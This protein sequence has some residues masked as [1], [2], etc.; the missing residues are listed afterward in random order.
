MTAEIIS[1]GTELLLGNI[2]NTNA[3][4]LSRELADLG[5]MVQ[6]ESTIG[7]NH[8]RL[9]DFVNEA[10]SRCDL[11]VFTGGLG[12]TADDLTKETVAACFGDELAFD[13]AEWDKITSYFARTGRET[14]PN[15]RKQA[16]VPT[17][18][19]KIINNHG[20]APGA[21]FEQDGHCAVLMPG[22]PH[23]MKA[24][25]TESVRPLLMERQNCTLH[26]VTLRVLGGESDIE[27]K[28]RDLLENPNP[29]AAIYCKTGECEIRITARARSD[30][31]GEKMCLA[32][33]TA[34]DLTKETVAA[35]FGDE[36]AFDEAEWDKITSYFAR[37]GRET[38]PN[39]RKQAMVPTK[40]HK[41]INNHG[42]A[43]GAWF[44]QDGHCAVLMP[45]V[46]HEMKA[47]WTESVRPLLMERQNC[48]LH[49]VTLR[50]LG[51]ESDIEYKVRDLLENPNPTAAIYCKTGE[52]EIRITARARSD[53]DGEKMCLAYAKKFY[54]MLGDA[55]Y[56][57]DVAGLEE[58]VVHTLQEKGLT[59]ATAESCTGGLIAQRLTSVS[60][61]SEVFGYGFVTYW[62]QAK[63]KLVG[64][65]P[66]VIEKYNVVSAPVAA[67]MALGA[68]KASGAD[69]AVSVT[70]VAGP[71]GGDE[72]RPVGT[73]Y[74]GAARDGVAYVKK[75]F[76]SRPDRALV[77][78]RAAQAALELALRL[79]QGKVPAGTQALT[80]AQQSDDEALAALDEAFV[81]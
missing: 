67:Q 21:W 35:C 19:H 46:P 18:G 66:A 16:M 30:E 5:I 81:R 39:N 45:G 63:A 57:E 74:L 47:M 37:T 14:T 9:A 68:A 29:T 4:Y 24:M 44:E 32:Y 42:T 31:D 25:W 12:P 34:D 79:A 36:L 38:T 48:T 28:V 7:D 54:D 11:L 69:I 73:V 65:D 41:I 23:E 20:T 10:K 40:G 72:V 80:A 26:S 59:I 15:N 6:R 71:T 51:G 50:V 22:V 61:S 78:A 77:R 64:V 8:G 13:E 49:S 62:E 17:K 56:D 58:T 2:L 70:G 60:G 75:L 1:V 3:Q 52:C 76:V 53:E 33:A 55:V 43:P 27:Y